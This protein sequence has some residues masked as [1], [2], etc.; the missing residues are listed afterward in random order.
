MLIR[1]GAMRPT[2]GFH[3]INVAL[4]LLPSRFLQGR[5]R[6]QNL[7]QSTF[8]TLQFVRNFITR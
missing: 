5:F 2:F 6:F 1:I 8:A 7:R 3:L 4:S